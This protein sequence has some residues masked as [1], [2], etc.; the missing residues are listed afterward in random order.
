LRR[1]F[2]GKYSRRD[3]QH[4]QDQFLNPEN[5]SKLN[6]GLEEEWAD[7]DLNDDQNSQNF[8]DLLHRVQHRVYLEENEKSRK[9]KPLQALQKIAA[10]LFI[11]LILSFS[12]Y[13]FVT[14]SNSK[15]TA[16]AEIQ[17][18]NGVRTSF[19]LPD[20]TSGFL[21]NGSKLRYR[22]P[23]KKR[24]VTLVGEAF[25]DVSKTGE[26]FHVQTK[27][28]D[29]EVMG[30][31]FNVIAYENDDT[32]EVILQTGKVNVSSINGKNLSGLKPDQQLVFTLKNND[33][34][35]RNVNASLFTAWYQGKLVFRNER[36]ADVA[37][38]IGRWYNVDIE[39][40][41]GQLKNYTF[42]A[43]FMNHSLN[44]VLDLL[45][46]T[47]P[48]SYRIE[49]AETNKA[50]EFINKKKVILKMDKTKEYQFK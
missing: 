44:E 45:T 20:G 38:R 33:F 35:V 32:E 49:K 6:Q 27:N 25:F 3:F 12:A 5:R 29:V 43:T 46:Y 39:I 7:F 34:V 47:S 17:C 4:V 30:T 19:T 31:T 16:L 37:K 10:I 1:Y 41:D 15:Q 36:L 11:P 2:S 40:A 9:L 48:I 42:H 28:L 24:E 22:V 14:I 13:L 18:P 26:P 21:N 50:N 8:D 23:F